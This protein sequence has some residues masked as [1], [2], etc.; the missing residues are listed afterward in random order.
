MKGIIKSNFK[1]IIIYII[2]LLNVI[3]VITRI[4]WLSYRDATVFDKSLTDHDRTYIHD[5]SNG[6]YSEKDYNLGFISGTC[7]GS[8]CCGVGMLYDSTINKCISNNLMGFENISGLIE[9]YETINY[10]SNIY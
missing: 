5:I 9:P 7:V 8:A 4:Y 6:L 3:Y 2:I 1:T 10:S